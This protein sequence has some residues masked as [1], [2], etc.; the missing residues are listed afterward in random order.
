MRNSF[1]LLYL[2][3]A[4]LVLFSGCETFSEFMNPSSNGSS[5]WF[6]GTAKGKKG[7]LEELEKKAM[8]D[9]FLQVKEEFQL[10]NT[11]ETLRALC[12]GKTEIKKSAL[13]GIHTVT[14][15]LL[16]T[17]AEE[18][19]VADQA[20]EEERLHS[21]LEKYNEAYTFADKLNVLCNAYGIASASSYF[22]MEAET[23]TERIG[24]L[25][26]SASVTASSVSSRYEYG[27]NFSL[28]AE[29][30]PGNGDDSGIITLDIV[31]REGNIFDSAVTNGRGVYFGSF[32][33][34]GVKKLG[35]HVYTVRINLGNTD[36]A[37][38]LQNI[39][40]AELAFC[41]DR[42]S[43]TADI[44]LEEP[45]YSDALADLYRDF[46]NSDE[47]Q[48]NLVVPGTRELFNIELELYTGDA[49]KNEQGVYST[50]VSGA[51]HIS[52]RNGVV[53][54]VLQTDEYLAEGA[55]AQGMME[56]ALSKL[57]NAVRQDS[58]FME[59]F[60]GIIYRE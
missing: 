27:E 57:L 30:K 19:L 45:L 46:I 16:K 37:S 51:F 23:V 20:S 48:L 24:R 12:L 35:D 6:T 25:L 44:K 58:S 17:D 26:E 10:E 60:K 41:V 34:D 32:G 8:E 3:F 28:L 1:R 49:V 42:I 55:T 53:I 31:D 14:Y 18:A 5:E 7:E 50:S 33:E 29:V 4:A 43:V 52:D 38:K 15:K 22:S 39:P 13:L 40:A 47:A 2:I 56:T 9:M 36:L 11:G 54:Y 59:E 21:A